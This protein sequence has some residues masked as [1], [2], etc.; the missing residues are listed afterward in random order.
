LRFI[1][2]NPVDFL[3]YPH[4]ELL[5]IGA[6]KAVKETLG[7]AVTAKEVPDKERIFSDLRLWRNEH[8]I[9]PLFKGQWA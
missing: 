2:V 5:L 7:I 4:A 6:H 9:K 1:P 3:D 8:T